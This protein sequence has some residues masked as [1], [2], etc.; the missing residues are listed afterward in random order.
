[1]TATQCVRWEAIGDAE[2]ERSALIS[3]LTKWN[4]DY[5]GLS[6]SANPPDLPD[7][8]VTVI[9]DQTRIDQL[10]RFAYIRQEPSRL[11]KDEPN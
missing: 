2:I 11:L 9:G 8:C 3:L 10:K 1:V 7:L 5:E 6:V 4:L